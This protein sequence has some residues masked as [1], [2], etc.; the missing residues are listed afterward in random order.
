MIPS[1]T[2]AM[3]LIKTHV[4]IEIFPAFLT[5][6]GHL[7]HLAGHAVLMLQLGLK[8]T[9]IL[10][11]RFPVVLLGYVPPASLE[12]HCGPYLLVFLDFVIFAGSDFHDPLVLILVKFLMA[13]RSGSGDQTHPLFVFR[14]IFLDFEKVIYFV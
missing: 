2:L 12:S 8:L 14:V 1:R 9:N 3:K 11:R 6:P 5:D 13:K 7:L 4:T 10:V